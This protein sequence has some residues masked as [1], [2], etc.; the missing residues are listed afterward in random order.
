MILGV[1]PARGGS[2]GVPRK[3]LRRIEGL[4]L[5]EWS[6]RAAAESAL[7]D[8]SVV[9]TEDP[10][11]ARVAREAGSEVLERPAA[12]AT[13]DAS[14]LSVLEH[15]VETIPA[16]VVVVLQPTSPIRDSGLIDSCIRRFLESAADSLATGYICKSVEYGR[17][18]LRRQDIDGFFMDDGNVYV[19]RADRIRQGDRYGER[20]ERVLLDREQNVEIDDEYDFWVAGQI[21]RKRQGKA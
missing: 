3:N 11:I 10:E 16:E 4:P 14:T 15:L 20:I 12:L 7:L 21:L 19:I 1:I 9:S 17:N 6:I 5:I 2:K 8:R 18:V 13:D